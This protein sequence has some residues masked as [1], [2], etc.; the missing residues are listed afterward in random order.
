MAMPDVSATTLR[1]YS[2][3]PDYMRAADETNDDFPL[4][5][6]L[7]LLGDQWGE[8]VDLVRRIDYVP[9]DELGH[10]DGDT[11]DLVDPL[12]ADPAWLPW[13]AQLVGVHLDH[14]LPVDAQRAQLA[15]PGSSWLSG[16]PGSLAVLA[17]SQLTDTK[18]VQIVHHYGGDPWAIAIRTRDSETPDPSAVLAAALPAKPAGFT[19]VNDT[20]TTDWDTLEAEFPTWADWEA[21]GNWTTIMEAGA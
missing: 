2:L 4:L 3:L 9:P 1:W 10:I 17:A 11:S 5:R 7:S 20:F 6:F 12:T 8:L 21:A 16:T 13:I 14:S 18:Y 15:T 19:L